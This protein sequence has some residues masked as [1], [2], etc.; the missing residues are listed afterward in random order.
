M[1]L[2]GIN[3]GMDNRHCAY[4][5]HNHL[6]L[7]EARF[8]YARGKTGVQRWGPLW[9]E[10]VESLREAMESRPTPKDPSLR[11]RVFITKYGGSWCHE[12]KNVDPIAQEMRKLCKDLGFHQKGVG[13]YSLRHTFYTI[14]KKCKDIEAVKFIMGHVEEANDMGAF[15]DEDNFDEEEVDVERLN[16]VVNFVRD[17]LFKHTEVQ[18]DA[19]D[20]A[21]ELAQEHG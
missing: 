13:F 15:Y 5:S 10:T 2:L 6:N 7:Q 12:E 17:W 1:V 8:D 4:L 21:S 20:D 18:A 9:P 14:A 16:T 19:E 3:C 11:D